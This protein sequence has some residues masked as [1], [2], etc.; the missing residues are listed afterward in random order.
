VSIR[1]AMMVDLDLTA[2]IAEPA[3]MVKSL[4]ADWQIAVWVWNWESHRDHFGESR[5]TQVIFYKILTIPSSEVLFPLTR[6]T[7][8]SLRNRKEGLIL[9]STAELF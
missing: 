3:R 6:G 8:I 2:A 7:M 9:P 5:V 1:L 4:V